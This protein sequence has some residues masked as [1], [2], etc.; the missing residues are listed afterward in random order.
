MLKLMAAALL[1]EGTTTLRNCPRILDVPLMRDVLVGLGCEVDIDGDVVRI[2]TPAEVSPHA[3]FDAVRQFRASV[4]V[5]G[6][7]VAR[8]TEAYVALPGGDAIG[9]RPLDMHQS[10]LEKLGATT[11]IEH[12][13]VVAR[14]DK[15]TGAS[16]KLD[17]PS[18]GATEN[19]VTAAV[20]ADG[21]TAVS[22]THLTLPTILLV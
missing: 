3:D 6:P 2:H 15:L 7:L 14:A 22:Y 10:G 1:A 5:L 9:S 17:F 20:L 8:C 12:G 4:A 16:I 11:H 18:V 13:A 19:I 21:R